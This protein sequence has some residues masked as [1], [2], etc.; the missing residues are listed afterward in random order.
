MSVGEQRQTDTAAIE[1]REVIAGEV[2]P[3]RVPPPTDPD[4]L[5]REIRETRDDLAD[6]LSSLAEKTKLKARVSGQFAD[7]RAKV[8]EEVKAR[9]TTIG[10]SAAGLAALVAAGVV[11]VVAVRRRRAQAR[12][13]PQLQAKAQDA[14]SKAY[15]AQ[16]RLRAAQSKAL[17]R[18][19]DTARNKAKEAQ[20]KARKSRA[21]ATKITKSRRDDLRYWVDSRR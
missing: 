7:T 15:E 6:A 19:K 17:K 5:R 16:A 20:E 21:K 1:R 12:A 8:T 2:E 3:V 11:T 10:A 14:T 18:A 13:V 9:K 4:V